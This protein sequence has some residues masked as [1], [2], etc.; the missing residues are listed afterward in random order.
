MKT[1]ILLL[2]MMVCVV[3]AGT[4]SASTKSEYRNGVLT[5]FDSDNYETVDV[6]AQV[7]WFDE[8]TSQNVAAATTI[9]SVTA[10]SS[11]TL[12]ASATPGGVL[13][14]VNPATDGM[15]FQIATS[16]DW[17]PGKYCVME[18]R[19]KLNSD[20]G[21]VNIG[22][23]DAQIEGDNTAAAGVLPIAITT[24]TATSTNTDGAMFVLD[25]NQTTDT[26]RVLAVKAGTDGTLTST[27][28]TWA[29]N[30]WYVMRVEINSDGDCDFWLDGNHI[31]QEEEGITTTTPLCAYIGTSTRSAAAIEGYID[32]IR[33]WQ[34]R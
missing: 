5:F 31:Y 8:F 28:T 1:K 18:A 24:N 6:M 26:I 21:A 3:F 23:T 33:V 2:A 29:D 25:S 13:T 20:I 19:F 7:K 14:M 30:T 34:K 12:V 4:A 22:F 32:Y 10:R 17:S 9:Y 15:T 27:S 16:L 11:G